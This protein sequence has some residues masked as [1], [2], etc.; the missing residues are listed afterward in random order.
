ME[1]CSRTLPSLFLFL[2]VEGV[3]HDDKHVNDASVLQVRI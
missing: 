1:M 3:P 2:A